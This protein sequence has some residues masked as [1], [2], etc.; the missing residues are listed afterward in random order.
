KGHSPMADPSWAP[1]TFNFSGIWEVDPAWVA[2]HGSEVQILDVREPAE[3]TGPLG[4]IRGAMLIPLGQLGERLGEL[5]KD[6]PV[7]A[8]CKSGGRSAQAVNVLR[9]AGFSDIANLP[10]GMMGW[11]DEGLSAEGRR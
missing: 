5:S 7:V 2:E 11:R 1:L 3:F 9:Q 6:E 4:H 10:G 8:V